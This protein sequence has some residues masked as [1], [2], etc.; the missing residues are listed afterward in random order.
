M[1]KLKNKTGFSLVE[2]LVAFIISAILALSV[3]V[4]SKI[5]VGT[6]AKYK[7]EMDIYADITYAFKLMQKHVREMDMTT[8]PL[9]PSGSWVSQRLLINYDSGKD[10]VFGLYQNALTNSVD[11]VFLPDQ[12][13]VTKR[14]VLFSVPN[15][16]AVALN[17]SRSGS[18][19]TVRIQGTKN[20]IPFDMSTVILKRRG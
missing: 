17:V 10:C 8:N 14:D 3:G 20:K 6:S 13:D 5:G 19:Y 15:P 11:L 7:R 2:M 16:A 1:H 12:S 4:I 18:A 9:A